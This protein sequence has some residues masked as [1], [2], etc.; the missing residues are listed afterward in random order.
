MNTNIKHPD[1]YRDNDPNPSAN[2]QDGGG[3][4]G[5]LGEWGCC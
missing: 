3:C 2:P 5:G 1:N 4:C